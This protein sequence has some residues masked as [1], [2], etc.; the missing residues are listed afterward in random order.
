MAGRG[1]GKTRAGAEWVRKKAH[2]FPGCRIALI[3]RTAADVR[4]TMLLGQ[5]GIL[6]IHPEQDRPN[7][8][9]S[10]RR[11][12]WPKLGTIATCYSAEKPD[13][14]RGPQHHF[15]WVDEL[16]AFENFDTWD[17]FMFGLRL[18]TDPRCVVTTTP[19]PVQLIRDLVADEDTH[20]VT[21]ST[22]D[23]KDN[24][25]K[26]FFKQILKKYEGTRL[27]RQEIEAELLE[28][29][30]GALWTREMINA[31][32][33]D[34]KPADLLRIVIG[35]DPAITSKS[36]NNETGIVVAAQDSKSNQFYVLEDRTIRAS[37]DKWARVAVEQYHEHKADLIVAEGN[38]GGDMVKSV[39][40]TVDESINVKIV[41]ATRGKVVRAEPIAA[42]YEQGKVH[43]VGRFDKLED[44]L[45]LFTTDGEFIKSP[46][47]AD[48]LV[49]AMTELS[50]PNFLARFRALSRA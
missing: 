19:R 40:Q 13:Q 20:V 17:Q 26:T 44:Q 25:A 30:P 43:H 28:D 39:L 24:L 10:K 5:S 15:G 21:G 23:N 50:E 32:R 9:P 31:N 34:D 42:L 3:G 7:Y 48:A 11:I 8:E 4:D 6:N 12:I 45:C 18:G 22:Y 14:L 1:F 37:P 16:A 36:E 33:V 38:Q 49:W 41:H 29:I 46:D 27:G 47:R 35:I 2:Q